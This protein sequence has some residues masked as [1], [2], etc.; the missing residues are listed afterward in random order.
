MPAGRS[1]TT[2]RRSPEVIE[3]SRGGSHFFCRHQPPP[4]RVSSARA[5][6]GGWAR[7][8]PLWQQP[9]AT[10]S[11]A[12]WGGFV[13]MCSVYGGSAGLPPWLVKHNP[14]RVPGDKNTPQ[15]SSRNNP[16]K[17][18]LRPSLCRLLR[19]PAWKIPLRLRRTPRQANPQP[20]SVPNPVVSGHPELDGGGRVHLRALLNNFF[21]RA[22]PRAPQASPTPTSCP[23]LPD[24][25]RARGCAPRTRAAPE[26]RHH[27]IE[28]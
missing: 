9:W 26:G 8:A 21:R 6:P 24:G 23:C 18:V 14:P 22:P 7:R 25:R 11:D 17:L 4:R 3:W 28:W 19:R 10:G 1:K 2:R 13:L 27:V 20:R 15:I 16:R 12:E 5:A